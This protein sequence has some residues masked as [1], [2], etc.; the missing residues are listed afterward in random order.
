MLE[1]GM[2]PEQI[3][4]ARGVAPSTVYLH[5][6]RLIADKRVALDRV[7][8]EDVV[9]AVRGAVKQVGGASLLGPVKAL[10]PDWISYEQIRCVLAADGAREP[11]HQGRA[12]EVVALGEQGR[13]ENVPELAAALSDPDGN[14]RRLAASALGKIGDPSGA[15]PLIDL[16]DREELPQVRQYAVKALGRIGDPC[17]RNVLERIAEGEKEAEYTRAAARG[18]LARLG[19]RGGDAVSR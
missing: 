12:A 1:Q 15:K 3:A 17:A 2:S 9:A 18:A 6:S 7:I 14:V 11:V 5:L 10:L 8:P 13:A 19:Q 4:E 16:L